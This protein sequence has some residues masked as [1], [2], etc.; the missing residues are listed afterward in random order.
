[1]PMNIEKMEVLLC[2]RTSGPGT[3]NQANL[4]GVVLSLE[5]NS[6]GVPLERV[7]PLDL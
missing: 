3:V 4:E 1:M 7:L 5:D 6:L 2:S